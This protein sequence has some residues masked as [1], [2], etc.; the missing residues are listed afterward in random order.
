MGRK[1]RLVLCGITV[2]ETEAKMLALLARHAT[3]AV[4]L[5]G[6]DSHGEDALCHPVALGKRAMAQEMGCSEVSVRRATLR[7]EEAGLI[8]ITARR[9]ENG[10][11]LENAYHVTHEGV[12]VLAEYTA[13]QI[14]R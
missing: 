14:S 12:A 8:E 5:E 10:G 9:L 4:A 7:L 11:Q 3:D 1:A 6:E 2:N 13:R